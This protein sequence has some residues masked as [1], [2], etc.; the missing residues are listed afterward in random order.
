MRFGY[1]EQ[2]RQDLL[3]VLEERI[4]P[5]LFTPEDFQNASESEM[6][7]IDQKAQNV[8]NAFFPD[9]NFLVLHSTPNGNCFWNR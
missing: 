9:E 4:R 7:I 1:I 8:A 6:S 3:H 5:G 2:G